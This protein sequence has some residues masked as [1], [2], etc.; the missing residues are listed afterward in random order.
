M[1]LNLIICVVFCQ[2]EN[3][4]KIVLVIDDHSTLYVFATNGTYVAYIELKST[5]T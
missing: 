4:N 3:E 2:G 5:I 1:G